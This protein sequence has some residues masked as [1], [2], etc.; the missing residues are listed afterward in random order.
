MEK[1]EKGKKTK[2]TRDR[3]K[4][5]PWYRRISIK[6]ALV[7]TTL[8]S[9]VLGFFTCMA[10]VYTLSTVH[11]D[12]YETYVQPYLPEEYADGY[13][14][15]KIESISPDAVSYTHLT[16]PTTPYV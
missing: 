9:I 13:Y 4:N 6:G 3:K 7:C 2:R 5:T 12:I 10:E 15:I 16:L 11:N 1:V 14:S 8:C